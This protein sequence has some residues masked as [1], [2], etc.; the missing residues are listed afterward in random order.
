MA[1]SLQARGSKLILLRG[2]PQ[3]QLPLFWQEHHVTDLVFES[4]TGGP[5][6]VSNDLSLRVPRFA[7]QSADSVPTHATACAEPY[8]RRRDAAIVALAKADNVKVSTPV[9]HTLYVRNSLSASFPGCLAWGL[10]GLHSLM[11]R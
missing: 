3:E 6:P 1:C 11:R 5:A 4:D 7:T 10:P 2:T 8:A 9:G